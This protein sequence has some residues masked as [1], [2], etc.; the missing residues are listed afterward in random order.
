MIHYFAWLTVTEALL[1]E[2]LCNCLGIAIV[3]VA[4]SNRL[5]AVRQVRV[6]GATVLDCL[7]LMAGTLSRV[8][9]MERGLAVRGAIDCD[10]HGA[11]GC[12]LLLPRR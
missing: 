7:K 9:L 6:V 3:G 11:I 10:S 8:V 5:R 2:D 1:L 12:S 4:R